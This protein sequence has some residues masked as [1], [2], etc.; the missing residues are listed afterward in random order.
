MADPVQ[1]HARG[2][3]E[4]RRRLASGDVAGAVLLHARIE[5]Q[6]GLW[7]LP[8]RERDQLIAALHGAGR[9]ADARPHL[10]RAAREPGRAG[11]GARLLLAKAL[12][13]GDPREAYA[14]LHAID[15]G[16]L[17]AADRAWRTQ[18][19]NRA[20][21]A[22]TPRTALPVVRAAPAAADANQ[23]GM[24]RAVPMPA[25]PAAQKPS[26]PSAPRLD[27]HGLPILGD[28]A[29][30]APT[31]T[32]AVAESPF[33]A[34]DALIRQKRWDEARRDLETRI[35]RG[36]ADADRARLRLARLLLEVDARAAKALRLLGEIAVARLDAQQRGDLE[37]LTREANRQIGGS[38]ARF[39]R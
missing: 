23:A 3:D 6:T 4:L 27:A 18:A 39:T 31:T 8:P 36:D 1:I 21:D 5:V 25:Q 13:D 24:F 16:G 37:D 9:G 17:D 33:A 20:R 14:L 7:E 19:L 22:A 38:T 10:E 26:A 34:V 15:A 28:A 30:P 2:L 29:A 11:D 12:I 35:L 32:S